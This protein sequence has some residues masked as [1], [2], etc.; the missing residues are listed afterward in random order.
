[1]TGIHRT[2]WAARLRNGWQVALLTSLALL[3]ATGVA[4]AQDNYPSRAVRIVVPYTPG[5]NA[6]LV[7]RLYAKE[8]TDVLGQPVQVENRPGG[9]TNIGAEAVARS[10]PD[11]YTL[12]LL[13][14]TSHGIN[15]SLY[16][17]LPYDPIKDFSAVGL[18]AN[19]TF[20][21]VVNP[22]L[23][24]NNVRELV[25]HARANPNKLSFASPGNASPTHLAGE[26]LNRRAEMGLQHVP[27]KG[28]APAIVD[29]I[30]NR[31]LFLFSATALNFVK[32]GKLKVLAVADTKRWPLEPDIPSMAEAGFPN[33]EILSYFGLGVPAKT[34]DAIQ[35][36]L[37]A[38]IV[39]IGRRDDTRKRLADLGL[40]P[41]T[42]NRAE[43]NAYV[44]R[45]IEKWRPIVSTAGAKPE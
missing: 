25:A 19:T 7:T 8:L 35:E 11:G 28:D 34:P 3:A 38:A 21:L 24:V 36:K 23:P 45:E 20:Y 17:K 31:V 29:L 12:F 2:T 18:L 40:V 43:A 15:P 27:Y 1:M 4:N 26:M 5:G 22:A 30:A 42:G 16:A 37:N 13:Q 41:L 10:A 9:A 33:F 44:A 14:G 6:D 32:Q 39:E